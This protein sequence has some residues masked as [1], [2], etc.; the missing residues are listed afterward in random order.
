MIFPVDRDR[1]HQPRGCASSVA[2]RRRRRGSRRLSRGR[3]SAARAATQRRMTE[4]SSRAWGGLAVASCSARVPVGENRQHQPELHG[5]AS[6]IG[7]LRLRA[8]WALRMASLRDT[9]GRRACCGVVVAADDGRRPQSAHEHWW[10]RPRGAFGWRARRI[11]SK[12]SEGATWRG[13]TGS[14]RHRAAQ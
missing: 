6:R 7:E 1:A 11:M 4:V 13:C 3:R 5:A 8:I 14:E 2:A 9:T 10:R 12:G